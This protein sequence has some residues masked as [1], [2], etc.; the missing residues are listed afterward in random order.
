MSDILVIPD[1][2]GSHEWE[3]VK[4]EKF[5]YC[6]C[7]GDSCDC[8]E[9]RWPDQG[10][11]IKNLF[12]WIREDPKHRKY[13]CGNHDF[14]YF[15]GTKE[16]KLVSGHQAGHTA[17]LKTIFLA[18]ID[19]IDVAF[20]KDGW[21]FSH[22]GFS[23]T[24]VNSIKKVLHEILDRFPDEEGKTEFS[25]MEEYHEYMEKVNNSKLVWDENEFSVDFLNKIWHSVSHITSDD[26]FYYSFDELFDW[27]GFLSG[28]GDEISQGPLWIRQ[29]SLIKD[30]YFDKQCVG[31]T[32][33]AI[34]GPICIGKKDKN[35]EQEVKVMFFDSPKHLLAHFDTESEVSYITPLDWEKRYKKLIKVV[36]DTK[37]LQ[38]AKMDEELFKEKEVKKILASKTS[39][40][41]ADYLYKM[42]FEED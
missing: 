21:V 1:V 22:A 41:Q 16:G 3:R 23:K 8:W 40:R 32:E 42:F 11:N 7:L 18:N 25:S 33:L 5:D 12:A 4:K 19:L 34:D 6:V 36:N 20:E 35:T 31:H 24:W 17:E 39:K 37:S 27:H 10:E 13:V 15:T 30:A 28:S 2:H 38:V 14:S 26:N 29:N 9:N